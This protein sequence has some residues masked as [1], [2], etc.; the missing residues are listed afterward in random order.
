VNDL[1]GGSNV[2]WAWLV[3]ALLLG[4]AEVLTATTLVM[5][6]AIAAMLVGLTVALFPALAWEFQ[7][8]AFAS[9]S[10]LSIASW[11]IYLGKR[12]IATDEPR[13][14]RRAEQYVGRTVTLAEGIVDG[15]G[16]LRV[17]DI[18]WRIEGPDLPRGTRV[19]ITGA[20]GGLLIV[21][22]REEP[23]A[24]PDPQAS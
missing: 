10:L 13:L 17:D 20:D 15:H 7:L 6:M 9:L 11:R 14:N 8:I 4:V 5:W 21:A 3:L 2:H 22:P 19:V 12:P 16:R 24:P 1:L 18:L 23:P